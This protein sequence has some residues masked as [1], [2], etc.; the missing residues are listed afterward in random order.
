MTG[1]VCYITL[2]KVADESLCEVYKKVKF[3]QHGKL[4]NCSL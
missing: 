4:H 2:Q 3:I 1:V